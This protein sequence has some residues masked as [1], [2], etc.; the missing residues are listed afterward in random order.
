MRRME[1]SARRGERNIKRREEKQRKEI[2]G[3]IRNTVISGFRGNNFLPRGEKRRKEKQYVSSDKLD[4]E[5]TTVRNVGKKIPNSFVSTRGFDMIGSKKSARRQGYT[6]PTVGNSVQNYFVN[7]VSARRL[8]TAGPTVSDIRVLNSERAPVN[9]VSEDSKEQKWR[10]RRILAPQPRHTRGPVPTLLTPSPREEEVK[11]EVAQFQCPVSGASKKMWGAYGDPSSCRHY[12]ICVTAKEGSS[13][14][15]PVRHGCTR[16][17]L[18]SQQTETCVPGVACG[19]STTT[20]TPAPIYNIRPGKK[21]GLFVEF[22]EFL[23]R[24]RLF[25]DRVVKSLM[26]NKE[27]FQ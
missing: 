2:R 8:D 1:S 9:W 20:T 10:L 23:I 22:V 17:L 24:S 15:A 13:T 7:S 25:N 12:Y 11:E 27:Y 21:Q 5:D 3:E 18:F 14:P 19:S 4:M 6:N 16:G 26:D